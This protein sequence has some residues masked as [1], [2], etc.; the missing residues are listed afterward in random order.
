[1][2]YSNMAAEIIPEVIRVL[3]ENVRAVRFLHNSPIVVPVL[4]SPAVRRE[5]EAAIRCTNKHCP[6]IEKEQIII[7]HLVMR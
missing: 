7:L 6:A 4:E 5:G 2:Y 3:P 1:M